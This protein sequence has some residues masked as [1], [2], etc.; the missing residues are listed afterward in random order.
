[1]N[2]CVSLQ[3]TLVSPGSCG[4]RAAPLARPHGCQRSEEPLDHHHMPP[5]RGL[6]QHH[7]HKRHR[8]Q[9]NMT[10]QCKYSKMASFMLNLFLSLSWFG[11]KVKSRHDVTAAAVSLRHGNK[12]VLGLSSV[13]EDL[14]NSDSKSTVND[15]A[16]KW[17][18]TY[19]ILIMSTSTVTVSCMKIKASGRT[20]LRK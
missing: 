16:F 20:E 14:T 4:C 7:L 12:A 17:I 6:H 9:M 1:M 11:W 15:S 18:C 8:R 3:W 10:A 5:D 13:G 19:F 2:L